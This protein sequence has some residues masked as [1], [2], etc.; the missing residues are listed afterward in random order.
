MMTHIINVFLKEIVCKY[1]TIIK[2]DCAFIVKHLVTISLGFFLA[3]KI[4][5]FVF[6]FVIYH[7]NQLFNEILTIVFINVPIKKFGFSNAIAG[8]IQK[9]AQRE[10]ILFWFHFD[11]VD[12]VG[13]VN[14][15]IG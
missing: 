4:Q 6:K 15:E 5:V 2:V 7:Y 11:F 10:P 1:K 12:Y 14:F 9:T 13:V 3:Y 8:F